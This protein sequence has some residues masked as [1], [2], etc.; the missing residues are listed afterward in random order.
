VKNNIAE[1]IRGDEK[2]KTAAA[3]PF[4]YAANGLGDYNSQLAGG[5][6][7][8]GAYAGPHGGGIHGYN[9]LGGQPGIVG[10][11]HGLVGGHPVGPEGYGGVVYAGHGNGLGFGQE[12]VNVNKHSEVGIGPFGINQRRDSIQK[13]VNRI[14]GAGVGIAT[15]INYYGNQGVVYMGHGNGGIPGGYLGPVQH[16]ILNRHPLPYDGFGG[17]GLH[18]INPNPIDII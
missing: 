4:G 18:G 13:S 3:T 2:F 15:P 14:E 8:A 5:A 11:G 7:A 12:Q 10:H 1:I 6:Y 17:H 16:N 9:I